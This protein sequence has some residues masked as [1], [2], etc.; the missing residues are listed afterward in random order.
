MVAAA[1][2]SDIG[3]IEGEGVRVE[4]ADTVKPVSGLIVHRGKLV[5]GTL[6]EGQAVHAKVDVERRDAIRRNHSATHLLHL[7]LRAELGDHVVQKGSLVAPDRL[8]FDFSHRAPLTDEQKRRIEAHV[9]RLILANVPTDTSIM[10][11]DDARASGAIGLFGEKYGDAVRVVRIGGESLELC[12]GTHVRRSGDIGS[13]AIVAEGGIAQGVRRVEAVTGM[14]AVEHLQ[15]LTRV[16]E[17]AMGEL[18]AGTPDEVL[19]RIEKLQG[20]LRAKEREIE[21]LQRKLATGGGAAAD[22]VVEVGGVKLLAKRVPVGDAK[23]LRAA[24]DTLR[25]RLGSGVV[26]LASES[27]G[28]ATLLVAVTKDLEGRV[29]AGKLVGSL[30]AHVD[31][32]GGG[33]PD[34]AQAGGPKVQ[35]IDDALAAASAALEEMLR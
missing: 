28:K 10:T 26:V 23:A 8:R 32:R 2:D 33:R 5:A 31:G 14:G 21:A 12:G 17:T 7:A 24:A 1:S 34:L 25:Q 15:H 20:D 3:V 6:R 29:H 18:H 35:G 27:D 11:P 16:T 4:I 22:A 30:A 19:A 13:F 9:N